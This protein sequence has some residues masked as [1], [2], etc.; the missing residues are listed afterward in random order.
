MKLAGFLLCATALVSL[1][2]V[3]TTH[4]NIAQVIKRGDGTL[5]CLNEDG[6]PCSA[7]QVNELKSRI[8]AQTPAQHVK[9]ESLALVGTDGTMRCTSKA[10]ATCSDA[11]LSEIRQAISLQPSTK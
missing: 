2:Q 9:A 11:E 4:K 5:Q 3:S 8:L 1:A 10:G 6:K 7:R